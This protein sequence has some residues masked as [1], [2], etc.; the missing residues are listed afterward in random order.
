[1]NQVIIQKPYYMALPWSDFPIDTAT[2]S[3]NH[4]VALELD[5]Y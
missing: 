3:R 2:L 1:M 4:Y 5:I